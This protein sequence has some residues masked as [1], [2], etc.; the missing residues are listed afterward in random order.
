VKVYR[1]MKV[2][3]ADGKPIVGT[4][5]GMLGVR[6]TDPA[7]TNPTSVFDVTAVNDTDN[8]QP[9]EGLSTSL[10]PNFRKPRRGEALFAIETDELDEDLKGIQDSANHV[11]I[12]PASPMQL[13]DY[14][15]ALE[16]TRDQWEQVQ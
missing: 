3:P 6:P 16:A 10:D 11:T 12:E 13:G 8:V 5:G 2:D 1:V 7:S 4:R 15:R 14:Q 9:G